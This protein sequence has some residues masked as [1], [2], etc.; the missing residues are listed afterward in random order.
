MIEF[1]LKHSTI[2]HQINALNSNKLTALDVVEQ[3][4][5]ERD[6]WELKGY[7]VE[8]GAKTSKDL[9][10]RQPSTLRWKLSEHDSNWLEAKESSI[11]VVAVLIATVTFDAVRNPP[12][13]LWQDSKGKYIAGESILSSTCHL[14]YLIFSFS[15]QVA[16]FASS[17][18]ILFMLIKARIPAKHLVR[19][20]TVLMWI[21]I[22]SMWIA[23]V[24]ALHSIGTG[25]KETKNFQNVTFIIIYALAVVAPVGI[26]WIMASFKSILS[27]V[28]RCRGHGEARNRIP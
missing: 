4:R 17:S 3:K 20:L 9:L 15:N 8:G 12:G 6:Y 18:T 11:L 24:S 28:G 16:F 14:S 7:L 23:F 21:G 22:V 2:K 1:L 26:T 10:K 5:W 19:M 13:G 27:I 25:A